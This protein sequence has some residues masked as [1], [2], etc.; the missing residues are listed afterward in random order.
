MML[1]D[2]IAVKARAIEGF[3][4]LQPVRVKM[5]KGRSAAVDVVEYAELEHGSFLFGG[6]RRC[7]IVYEAIQAHAAPQ[8]AKRRGGAD[9]ASH[10]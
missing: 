10:T 3:D 2:V 9:D 1:G 4:D 5:G 7:F 6:L 8:G